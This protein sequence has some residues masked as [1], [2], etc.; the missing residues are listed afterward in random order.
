MPLVIEDFSAPKPGRESLSRRNWR[1]GRDSNPRY[2]SGIMRRTARFSCALAKIP[3]DF[4]CKGR[5]ARRM[6]KGTQT[7]PHANGSGLARLR[8]LVWCTGQIG[9]PSRWSTTMTKK[10]TKVTRPAATTTAR[11]QRSTK[12]SRIV[13]LLSRPAGASIAEM[14]K[15][16]GWQAHSVRGFMSGHLKKLGRSVHSGLDAGGTRR[17]RIETAAS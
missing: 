13:G 17:Y 5:I 6:N 9:W 11:K 16:T 12:A 3:L 8:G 1:R 7:C 4:I 14:M 2:V 10:T 15:S